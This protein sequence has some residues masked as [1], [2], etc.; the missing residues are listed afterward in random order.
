MGSCLRETREGEERGR[1]PHRL[2]TS[3]MEPVSPGSGLLTDGTSSTSQLSLSSPNAMY[4]QGLT[5]SFFL[6]LVWR[7]LIHHPWFISAIRPHCTPFVFALDSPGSSPARVLISKG[8]PLEPF[9]TPHEPSAFCWNL[10]RYCPR[11]PF[12]NNSVNQLV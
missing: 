11:L 9:E 3:M 1:C 4:P 10:D 6:L 8:P 7:D 12:N 5:D 2:T